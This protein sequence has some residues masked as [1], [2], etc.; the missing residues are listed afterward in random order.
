MGESSESGLRVVGPIES[1]SGNKV[2][3][4]RVESLGGVKAVENVGSTLLVSSTPAHI[5]SKSSPS[6]SSIPTL[7]SFV[8]AN[9]EST[10]SMPPHTH[11]FPTRPSSSP[12]AK[13]E[14]IPSNPPHIHPFPTRPS[15]SPVAKSD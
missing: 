11:P 10:P 1:E 14:S 3:S 4:T 2:V 15:S 7:S 12:V 6:S 9:I 13:S 5:L 8:V